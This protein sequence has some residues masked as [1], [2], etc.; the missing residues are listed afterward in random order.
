MGS[1]MCIR[2]SV[3]ALQSEH[4]KE[5]DDKIEE[6]DDKADEAKFARD[7]ILVLLRSLRR[8]V[9]ELRAESAPP[10]GKKE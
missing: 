3:E 9:A 10:E 7:E 8:E 4:E 5:Q 2:D 6:L 1:E